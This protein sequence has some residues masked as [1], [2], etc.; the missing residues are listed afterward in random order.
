MRFER[1]WYEINP[2]LYAA[3]GTATI[4]Y[5]PGSMLMKASGFVLLFAAFTILGLRWIYR[6]DVRRGDE[7]D[8]RAYV[9]LITQDVFFDSAANRRRRR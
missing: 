8:Q 2:Y 9:D 7:L 3:A 6:Q 1:T 4:V 5:P